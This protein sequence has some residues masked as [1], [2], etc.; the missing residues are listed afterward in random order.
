MKYRIKTVE[1]NSGEKSFHVEEKYEFKD[2]MYEINSSKYKYVLWILFPLILIVSA[3]T[4]IFY[5][6]DLDFEELKWDEKTQDTDTKDYAQEY[7]LKK[8]S[9]SA[10]E[11]DSDYNNKIKATSYETYP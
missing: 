8:I 11:K 2:L 3:L 1:L 7:I 10:N 4:M 6:I 9:V 5:T